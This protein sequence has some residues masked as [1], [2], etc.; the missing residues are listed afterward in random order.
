MYHIKIG[1]YNGGHFPDAWRTIQ[2]LAGVKIYNQLPGLFS[3]GVSPS[4]V[5]TLMCWSPG[6]AHNN[7]SSA[8]LW[9]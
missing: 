7:C 3:C 9:S 2:R 6:H 1:E 8:A 4:Y 5:A